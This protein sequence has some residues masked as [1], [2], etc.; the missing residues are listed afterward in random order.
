MRILRACIHTRYIIF[1][2]ITSTQI[3]EYICIFRNMCYYRTTSIF[4]CLYYCLELRKAQRDL[5]GRADMCVGFP[6]RKLLF[7]LF[8]ECHTFS[9]AVIVALNS[10]AKRVTRFPAYLAPG[11][12]SSFEISRALTST[13]T[14]CQFALSSV[15]FLPRSFR[16]FENIAQCALTR[17]IYF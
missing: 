17:Y 1:R 10:R 9:R 6:R 5:Q 11:K 8:E 14:T 7:T 16:E 2:S 15:T 12:V 3:I 13:E 4:H